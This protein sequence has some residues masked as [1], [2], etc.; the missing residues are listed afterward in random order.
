MKGREGDI[1]IQAREARIEN[2]VVII[3]DP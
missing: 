2:I 3:Y 1:G